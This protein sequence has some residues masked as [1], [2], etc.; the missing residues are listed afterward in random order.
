MHMLSI[1][2]VVYYYVF[3]DHQ[4]KSFAHKEEIRSRL[5]TCR[6]L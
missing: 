2:N 5:C 4:G 1:V 6:L 3:I